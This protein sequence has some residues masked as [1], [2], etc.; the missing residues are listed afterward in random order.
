MAVLLDHPRG[1]GRGGDAGD[2]A[3]EQ[4]EYLLLEASGVA[5][6]SGIALTFMEDC[7]RDASGWTASCAS[8]TRSRFSLPADDGT[9]APPG[10]VRRHAHPQ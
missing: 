2:G 7:M 4:P 1:S 3:S 8:W 9:E 10:G 6:P 5:D